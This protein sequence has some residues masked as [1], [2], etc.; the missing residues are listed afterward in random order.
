VRSLGLIGDACAAEAV[1][2]AVPSQGG[3]IG[4]PAWVAAEALIGMGLGVAP[5][6]RTALASPDPAVRGVAVTVAGAATLSALC[7]EL[8]GMLEHDP[9][10]EVRT[11]AAVALGRLG[12]PQDVAPLVRQ[13]APSQPAVLRRTCVVALGEVGDARARLT[14]TS[15]LEEQDRRLAELSAEALVRIG[16]SGI[17]ELLTAASGMGPR[18]SVARGALDMAR[19]RGVLLDEPAR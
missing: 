2:A 19:L 3:R 17:H 8:R 9:S 16:P 1:L 4:V 11:G 15:L 6:V 12:S 7:P 18:A 5:V 14:L 10:P 13:T